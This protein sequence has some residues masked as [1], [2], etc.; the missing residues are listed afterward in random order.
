MVRGIDIDIYKNIVTLFYMKTPTIELP[1]GIN[2]SDL[3]FP[4]WNGKNKLAYSV[5]NAG[6]LNFHYVAKRGWVIATLPISAAK[7]GSGLTDRTYAV[8]VEEQATGEHSIVTVGK[9]PHVLSTITVYIT[10]KRLAKLQK[11][12]DIYTEG[13]GDAGSIRDRISTRRAQTVLRR[14]SAGGG[15]WDSV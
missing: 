11:F 9:G 14:V 6:R 13:L 4:A 15:A 5:A 10:E 2:K 12:V 3:K 7:R 8:Q 1:E